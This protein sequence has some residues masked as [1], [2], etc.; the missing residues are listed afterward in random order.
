[1]DKYI[2]DKSRIKRNSS[3]KITSVEDTAPKEEVEEKDISE[4]ALELPEIVKQAEIVSP[5]SM[6]IRKPNIEYLA[7]Y[8]EGS[9]PREG[10]QHTC[11]EMTEHVA[12]EDAAETNTD[13]LAYSLWIENNAPGPGRDHTVNT[14]TNNDDTGNRMNCHTKS[15]NTVAKVTVSDK[16]TADV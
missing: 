11:T 12:K 14:T 10:Y 4:T 7:T 13:A 15:G 5:E 9:N 8:N 16:G 1:M 3:F 6:E 2:P